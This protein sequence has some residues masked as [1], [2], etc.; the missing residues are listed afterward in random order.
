MKTYNIITGSNE[1]EIWQ[2]INRQISGDDDLLEYTVLVK[3]GDQEITLDIDIDLGGGF[4][5]G[6]ET[7][8]FSAP[9]HTAPSFK[10][11]VHPQHFTDEVGKFFGM[12]DV[13]IGYAP[14]DKKFIIK[15]DDK[16]KLREAFSDE[17]SRNTLLTLDD[18]SLG[19]HTHHYAESDE[20]GPFLELLIEK[21]IT[22]PQ[23]LR[24][25]YHAFYT[26]LVSLSKA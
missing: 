12:Q 23:V 2:Q 22:D 18:F 24:S 3:Q 25:L 11:A 6:Y 19:V 17:A 10:F 13:E 20:K 14:F 15:T 8:T 9:L 7:T 4:E 26:I 5:S 16:K 21:G 1:D